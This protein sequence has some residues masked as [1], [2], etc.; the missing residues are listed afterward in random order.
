[1]INRSP[2]YP[3]T[4]VGEFI[5]PNIDL[6]PVFS[7]VERLDWEDEICENIE[8]A[9]I[10]NGNVI[11]QID[12]LKDK[13]IRKST[14]SCGTTVLAKFFDRLKVEYNRESRIRERAK[15]DKKDTLGLSE[16]GFGISNIEEKYIA[17]IKK[18]L[19]KDIDRLIESDPVRSYKAYDRSVMYKEGSSPVNL[20]NHIFEKQ[21]I[22][23]SARLYFGLPLMKVESVCLHISFPD[24]VHYR[25]VLSDTDYNPKTVLLHFDPKAGTMKSILYL[26]EITVNDGPFTYLPQTH[27]LK[28]KAV[29]RLA[30]KS[31]C[32]VNYLNSDESRKSFMHLPEALRKTSIIGSVTDDNSDLSQSLLSQEKAFTSDQGNVIVFDPAILHRGGICKTGHRISLQIAMRQ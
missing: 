4:Y 3:N 28:T 32:T 15:H 26:K 2:G 29:E 20:I 30:A 16:N 21:D 22:L 1:M 7:G 17:E 18:T 31:N 23:P 10:N 14:N 25:Q 11:K 5:W 8:R 12:K 27:R 9:I 19:K 24:D 13:V 6:V